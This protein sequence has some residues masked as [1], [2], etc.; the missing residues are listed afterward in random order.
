MIPFK[1]FVCIATIIVSTRAVIPCA[2]VQ[3]NIFDS[4]PKDFELH[5]L[6]LMNTTRT[7]HVKHNVSSLLDLISGHVPCIAELTKTVTH[8]RDTRVE[9]SQ[10]RTLFT[11][12]IPDE[13]QREIDDCEIHRMLATMQT[14]ET[15]IQILGENNPNLSLNSC[16]DFAFRTR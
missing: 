9:P 3:V 4:R 13:T 6:H 12:V 1:L 14:I 10:R 2:D 5:V 16:I 7:F 15:K 8:L 11:K